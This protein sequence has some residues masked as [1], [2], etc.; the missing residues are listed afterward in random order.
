MRGICYFFVPKLY[1]YS[2]FFCLF[3]AYVLYFY[4]QFGIPS[5]DNF[6]CSRHG[7]SQIVSLNL[8]DANVIDEDWC[9]IIAADGFETNEYVAF[10]LKSVQWQNFGLPWRLFI[11]L[12]EI[13]SLQFSA[14]TVRTLHKRNE[15]GVREV[16]TP[17]VEYQ[18]RIGSTKE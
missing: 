16:L 14:C 9:T 11:Y 1:A 8:H 5:L 18:F 6:A 10:I 7:N 15:L 2:K 12:R 17:V 13:N 3:L 4:V